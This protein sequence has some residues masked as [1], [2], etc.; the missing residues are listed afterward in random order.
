MCFPLSMHAEKRSRQRGI[1]LDQIAVVIRHGDQFNER[2]GSITFWMSKR[3]VARA[4]PAVVRDCE[5]CRSLAVT[6]GGEGFIVTVQF[7]R[8]PK[9][10]WRKAL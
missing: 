8:R 1:R 5:S 10:L 3:A 9:R 7:V 2:G 4:D 6:V